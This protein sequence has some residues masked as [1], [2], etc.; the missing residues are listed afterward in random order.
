MK[1]MNIR[2]LQCSQAIYDANIII[3]YCSFVSVPKGGEMINLCSIETEKAHKL[4]KEL[5]EDGKTIITLE[6]IFDEIKNKGI[7]KL[8]D[9]FCDNHLILKQ[10][11]SNEI[12]DKVRYIISKKMEKKLRKLQRN[13][14]FDVVEEYI[15]HPECISSLEQFY[16]SLEGTPK[17]IEH[18]HKKGY[19]PP[20]Y[21]DH[22]L[23]CCSSKFNLLLVTNDTDITTFIPE[24]KEAG[25]CF[26]I[27]DLK[28][29]DA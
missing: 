9:D 12:P 22:A 7:A 20:S 27:F 10:F 29:Y 23:L 17:M 6:L 1:H 15:P 4:T 5:I 3:Y 13:D 18:H 25:H 16:L 24:L 14:W 19:N 28:R 8:V 11:N 26:E 21:Q 2:D